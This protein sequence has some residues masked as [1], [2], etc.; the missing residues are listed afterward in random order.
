MADLSE[1]ALVGALLHSTVDQARRCLTMFEVDDLDD[2]RHRVIVELIRHCVAN[3][4]QPSADIV[5]AAGR[6]SGKVS[7]ARLGAFGKQLADLATNDTLPRWAP[8]HAAAV[9]EASVRRRANQAATRFVQAA[10]TAST[11][12]LIELVRSECVDLVAATRRV[13][14]SAVAS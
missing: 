4:Q 10:D 13:E 3:G 6:T 1:S 7:G 12:A 5:F 14:S 2:V 11:E 8:L 9:V